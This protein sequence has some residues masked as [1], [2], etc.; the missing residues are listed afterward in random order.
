VGQAVGTRT[1]VRARGLSDV[2][3]VES[4]T[5]LLA[6]GG[7]CNVDFEPLREDAGVAAMVGQALPPASRAKQFL[8][9]FHDDAQD[10]TVAAR[11]V[12]QPS[13]VPAENAP[14]AG[15]HETLRATAHA[16]QVYAPQWRATLDLDAT[17][18]VSEKREAATTYTGERGYQPVLV[19]W[20]EQDQVVAD[21]F[22]D[23]NVPAGAALVG[24]LARAVAALPAGVER[25]YLRADSAAYTHDV[26][27]WCDEKQANG[28]PRV[29]FAISAD[30][31]RELR[32]AIVGRPASAWQH[33]ETQGGVARSWAEVPFVPAAS[34][35][36]K[37]RRPHRYLAIRLRPEQGELFA[38][39][40]EVKYFAVVTNDW[41]RDG[42][43]L[44]D[45]HRQKAGT[46]EKVHDVLKNGLGAGV[47]PCARFGANA[48]WLRLNALTY[49][50]LSLLRRQAL[51]KE[52]ATAG[53]KRLRFRVLCQAGELVRHAR[54]LIVRVRRLWAETGALFAAARRALQRLRRLLGAPP[55]VPVTA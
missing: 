7:E 20:A 47:L 49:N 52:L 10:A 42:A 6:A 1:P 41:G 11:R 14:L 38:D 2:E 18:I 53:P 19:S 12:E 54:R 8:Y 55:P 35:E 13:F 26:M 36:S 50:L 4:F 25:V 48:A 31:S 39:G 28:E 30:M 21:E 45:W 24:V 33:L 9:A 16:A 29:T 32:A 17:I 27:D 44:I 40:S 51:P 37:E 15:L 3:L 43:A 5:L 34:T 46:I 23:G 22:R